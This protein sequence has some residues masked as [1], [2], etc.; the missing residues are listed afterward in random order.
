MESLA[1]RLKE[2]FG[3]L[4]M[5]WPWLIGGA[6]VVAILIV[7]LIGWWAL[8]HVISRLSGATDLQKLDT[9]PAPVRSAL[10]RSDCTRSRSASER[11]Q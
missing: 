6:S 11:R 9:P 7:T 1:Q 2:G 4:L 3:S 5:Y 10:F 8:L